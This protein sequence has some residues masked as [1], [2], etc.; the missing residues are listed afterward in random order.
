MV[1]F[2]D[3]TDIK[4]NI[5]LYEIHLFWAGQSDTAVVPDN[6]LKSRSLAV[7]PSNLAF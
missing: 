7:I 1:K 4:V 6:L 5:G 2:G 3:A